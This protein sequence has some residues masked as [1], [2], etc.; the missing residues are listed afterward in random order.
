MGNHGQTWDDYP[1][2][3]LVRHVERTT[4]WRRAL[5]LVAAAVVLLGVDAVAA[6]PAAADGAGPTRFE[7]IID[8]V[9]P[10]LDEVEVSIVGGDAF[11]QVRAEDGTEVAIAGYD[12]EPYLRI[13]PDGSIWE[14]Q[15]SPS[16]YLNATRG[17]SGGRFP[18]GVSSGAEP[19]WERVGNGGVVAW[20]DHRIHWMLD[21]DPTVGADGLV[22]A[23]ELPIDVDGTEV[24][25]TGRLLLEG[26]VFPWALGVAVVA[27]A[28]AVLVGRSTRGRIAVLAVASLAAV[29]TSVA[30][31][32]VNPPRSGASVIPVAL[33]VIAV[34]C[35]VA[36]SAT[37]SRRGDDG[38][39]HGLLALAFPLGAVAALLGWVV[40][41][42]GVF[43]MAN[44]PTELPVWVDRALTGVVLGA[45]LGTAVAVLL[46]PVTASTE[47][48]PDDVAQVSSTGKSPPSDQSE[49]PP[50]S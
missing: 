29:A 42:M 9:E 10:D 19:E 39:R 32:V 33:P 36:A 28:V 35:T 49:I 50:R 17:G 11:I 46:R 8:A 7:S 44:V 16:V 48:G 20:H 24:L 38:P 12:G 15:R 5:A 37:S 43:W 31:F 14:N 26:S 34:L 6:D 3:A 30:A 13:D 2:M 22:Q 47:P 41:R 45:A 27:G 4:R 23:W 1:E 25:V 18:Q 21:E 40:Q